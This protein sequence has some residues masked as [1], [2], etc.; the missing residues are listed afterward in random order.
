MGMIQGDTVDNLIR[1][2]LRA[3]VGQ[4][5]PSPAVREALLAVATRENVARSGIGPSIPPLATGLCEDA[6][7]IEAPLEGYELLLSA[8]MGRKQWLLLA[9][10]LYAVR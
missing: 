10:P 5:E 9:A 3:E 1:S 6:D 8:A 7:K 2:T 4:Q